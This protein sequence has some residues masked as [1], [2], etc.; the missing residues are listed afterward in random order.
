MIYK[1]DY[2]TMSFKKIPWVRKYIIFSLMLI[3][4]FITLKSTERVY[5]HYFESENIMLVECENE[6]SEEKLTDKL[7]ELNLR[8]PWIVLAQARRE[9]GHYKFRIFKESNNLFGMKE[10]KVR[11]NVA[12][13]T[14]FNHAYYNSWEESVLDYAFWAA[15]FAHKCDTEEKYFQLLNSYA[16][17]PTYSQDLQ[18]DIKQNKLKELFN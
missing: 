12:K 10:A 2:K 15:T 6:F 16:E 17:S 5:H 7:S 3:G 11:I 8:F 18:G 1:Y 13:G 9:S 4:L 14:Q